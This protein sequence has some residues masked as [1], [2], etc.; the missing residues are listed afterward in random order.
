M[1]DSAGTTVTRNVFRSGNEII[2]SLPSP[3]DNKRVTFS[4]INVNS[5][6]ENASVSAGFLVG[7]MNSSKAITASD[8]DSVKAHLNQGVNINTA[9]FNVSLSGTI[10]AAD[11][12]AVKV[13]SGTVLK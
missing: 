3:G 5:V 9:K 8:N 12:S 10:S 7:D 6:G 4:A 11:V 2:V 1:L 13:R